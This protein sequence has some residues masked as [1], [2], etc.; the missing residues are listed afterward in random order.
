MS[1]KL[2]GFIISLRHH[3]PT[4]NSA[5]PSQITSSLPHSLRHHSPYLI[6]PLP[7]SFCHH[8]PTTNATVLTIPVQSWPQLP[9]GLCH[10]IAVSYATTHPRFIN[11]PI[12]LMQPIP[13]CILPLPYARNPLQ[14][15]NTKG[16]HFN[17]TPLAKPLQY[18]LP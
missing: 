6:P 3:S 9:H 12:R 16:H 4:N 14:N 7:H 15:Y 8:S 11:T 13:P 17:Y 2:P 10:Q 1:C 5:S 18:S